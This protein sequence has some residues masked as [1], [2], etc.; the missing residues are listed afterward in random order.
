MISPS[1]ELF[2]H[3]PT[4]IQSIVYCGYENLTMFIHQK[5]KKVR[6]Q[7]TKFFSRFFFTLENR[8]LA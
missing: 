4:N 2:C 5:I 6:N 1:D 3:F 8:L 7:E